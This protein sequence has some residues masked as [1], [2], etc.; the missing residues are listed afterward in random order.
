MK[1]FISLLLITTA[2]NSFASTTYQCKTPLNS[3]REIYSEGT[4]VFTD[5]VINGKRVLTNI[6]AKIRADFTDGSRYVHRGLF[7]IDDLEES[8]EFDLHRYENRYKNHSQFR[9]FNTTSSNRGTMWGSLIVEKSSSKKE[10]NA[11]Y[12]FQAGDHDFI[13]GVI[14][15]KCKRRRN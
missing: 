1:T 5:Q 13:E 14:D 12:I 15:F 6:V 10:L 9:G 11:H 3:S 2:I 4:L 8:F 7:R